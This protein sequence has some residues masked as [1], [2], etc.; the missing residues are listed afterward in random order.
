MAERQNSSTIEQLKGSVTEAIG[1][2]TGDVR[3]E[4]EGRRQKRE[5]GTRKAAKPARADG[6]GSGASEGKRR[7]D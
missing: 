6:T 7:H 3:A 5:A 2:L 1:K 4:A